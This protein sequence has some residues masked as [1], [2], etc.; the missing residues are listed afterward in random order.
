MGWV[1]SIYP[2]LGYCSL[3]YTVVVALHW[4]K[5]YKLSSF[6]PILLFGYISLIHVVT[7]P[8][9][10]YALGNR[11]HLFMIFVIGNL[12][13]ILGVVILLIIVYVGISKLTLSVSDSNVT[14]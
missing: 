6:D 11:A 12:A 4:L 5:V 8:I 1:R 14:N 3:I 2:L 10:W 7:V 9:L 13:F